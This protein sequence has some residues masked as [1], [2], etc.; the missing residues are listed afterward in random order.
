MV[1]Q[2][3]ALFPHMTV[4]E[5]VSYGPSV[6]GVKKAEAEAM[7]ADKLA[8]VGLEGFEKRLPSELSGGQQQR[9]AVARALVLEPQV[10]LFDEPLSNLDAKLRR[11]VREDIRELQQRL[12]LTVAYVTHDQQE[13]LAVSDRIIVM[14]NARIAQSGTPRDLYE[15]PA[16]LFVADFIGDSNL[17]DVEVRSVNGA[18]AEVRLADLALNLP[19]RAVRPGPAKIA[20]RPES[21]SLSTTRCNRAL[22][23][24]IVKAAYLGTHMEY[25]VSVGGG[26]RFV[27]DRNVTTPYEVGSTVWVGLADH[28]VTLIP[29]S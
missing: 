19:A 18:S 14:S 23:G 10:L 21:L 26:D 1:F 20:V 13:A 17:I 24:R 25:T 9:V 16:S 22:E 2:S 3:Y 7:A 8:I 28:G 6:S 12:N 29:A 5:N 15:A 4:M 27:V 11:R